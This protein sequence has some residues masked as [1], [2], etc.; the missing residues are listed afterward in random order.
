MTNRN[1][2]RICKDSGPEFVEVIGQEKDEPVINNRFRRGG[3]IANRAI[4]S[5]QGHGGQLLSTV[6]E[7]RVVPARRGPGMLVE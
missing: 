7:Y 6:W 3:G 5:G 4:R 2:S 1:V